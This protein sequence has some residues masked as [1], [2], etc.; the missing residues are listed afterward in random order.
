MLFRLVFSNFDQEISSIFAFLE[1][2]RLRQ[3]RKYIYGQLHIL[4]S[5]KISLRFVFPLYMK[6]LNIHIWL[7]NKWNFMFT[8]GFLYEY[9]TM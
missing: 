1:R 7:K 5:P 2:L 9:G 4:E 6:T 3:K 8:S